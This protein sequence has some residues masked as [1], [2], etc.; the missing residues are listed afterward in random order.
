[1]TGF[2]V[3]SIISA[4]RCFM[5]CSLIM[6]VSLC[7]SFPRVRFSFVARSVRLMYSA[8]S[9]MT[10][11]RAVV[12]FPTF[13]VPVMRMTCLVILYG[14]CLR[15]SRDFSAGRDRVSGKSYP[16]VFS[17]NACLGLG[18]R[19]VSAE[20]ELLCMYEIG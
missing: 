14:P 20:T 18:V 7:L 10:S 4:I 3:L 1:M 16:H 8:S 5:R 15:F 17:L 11:W 13:G 9:F 2:W 19:Q 6:I 12:V